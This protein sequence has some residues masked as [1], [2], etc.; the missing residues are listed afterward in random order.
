VLSFRPISRIYDCRI[1]CPWRREYVYAPA[2]RFQRSNVS[3]YVFRWHRMSI[4]DG[5]I[6]LHSRRCNNGLMAIGDYVTSLDDVLE[7]SGFRTDGYF[8][9]ASTV[10][11]RKF[12]GWQVGGEEGKE[13][14][15]TARG[16]ESILS[17]RWS[18]LCDALGARTCPHGDVME[19][20]S[21]LL[22]G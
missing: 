1:I 4:S 20:V 5:F 22:L 15:R 6:T 13:R 2:Y 21:A 16:F 18:A 9:P 17:L 19:P 14:T 7:C 3:R 10:K 11:N 12:T 8:L